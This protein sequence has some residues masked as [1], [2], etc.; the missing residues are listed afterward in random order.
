MTR[1]RRDTPEE[2]FAP[3]RDF[4]PEEEKLCEEFMEALLHLTK[5]VEKN[6]P[7]GR[8]V[9]IVA[10]NLEDAGIWI[11]RAINRHGITK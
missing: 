4:T 9:N 7:A 2:R 3:I 5:D 6:I 10:R 8:E 11:E 1:F